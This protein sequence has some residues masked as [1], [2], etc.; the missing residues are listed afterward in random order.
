M[1]RQY[2]LTN[3][4]ETQFINEVGEYTL[5]V[6][7]VTPDKTANG[8]AVEKV[9]FKTKDGLQISDEFVV[10]DKA[11]WRMKIFTKALKLPTVTDTDT[12]INRYVVATVGKEGY[13]KQDGT[14]GEKHVITKYEPSQLT[15]TTEAPT[16][17]ANGVPVHYETEVNPF[18]E[19]NIP[20]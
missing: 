13:V 19:S 5:K 11:L 8:N 10:T 16:Q 1:G 2:D 9:I 18:D 4:E 12:W 7:S 15:N 6:I 3:V 17:T 20:L 14:K